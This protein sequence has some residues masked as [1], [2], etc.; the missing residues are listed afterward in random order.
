MKLAIVIPYYK[1]SYFEETLQSLAT[2]TDKRFK[3]YIG[4]DA[5]PENPTALLEKYKGELD[6]VY[7]RFESNLGGTSLVKQWER[8]IAMT[9]DEEWIMILGDDD[10]LGGDLVEFFWKNF[11]VFMNKTNVVRFA[12]KIVKQELNS[13]SETYNHPIWEKA[14]DSFFRKFQFCTRSSLSEHIFK[15]ESYDKFKFNNFPL[16]WYADDM[17]WMEF[18]ENKLIFSINEALVYIRYSNKSISGQ[19]NN[20]IDKE[21]SKFLFYNK[22]VENLLSNF[23]SYQKRILLME[24]GVIANEQNKL[25]FNSITTIAL[26]LAKNGSFYALAKFIRRVCRAKL[27]LI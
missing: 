23:N 18:S 5:S 13:I 22:I 16:A 26:Q 17:A 4:D 25:N 19:D 24:Y 14:S 7:H 10:F 21:I 8:C 27:N 6:F 9:G 15:R 20:L 2:Q 3:V 12:S 1:L 11:E